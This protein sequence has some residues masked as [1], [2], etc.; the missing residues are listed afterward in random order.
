MPRVLEAE[1]FVIYIYLNDHLPAHVH[2]FRGSFGGDEIVINLLDLSIREN[3]M[4]ASDARKALRLVE[5]YRD[6]LQDEWDR[7]N[8][9]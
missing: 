6:F 9:E 4:K 2:A 1:G 8:G 5:D 7:I 3:Y